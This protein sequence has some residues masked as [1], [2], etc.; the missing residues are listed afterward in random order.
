MASDAAY[1][2]FA[3][4]IFSDFS[5]SIAIPAVFAA[6][7]GKWLDAK[8]HSSP[9]FLFLFLLCAFVLTG[10]SLVKKAKKYQKEYESL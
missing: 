3:F 1:Y 6:I 2:R 9:K 5:G 8:Y 4:R 7:F 10:F